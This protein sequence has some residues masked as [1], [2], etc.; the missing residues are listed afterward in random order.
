MNFSIRTRLTFWYTSLLFVSL[1]AFG[2]AFSYSLLKIFIYRTDNQVSSVANMM[3]HTI[4]KPSGEL[5]LPR[6]FDI[7]LERFFGIRTAGNYIQVLDPHGQVVAKS[8]NLVFRMPIPKA[9]YHAALGGATTFEVVKNVG[10]YPVRVVTKP[11]FVNE[12]LV[13]IVQVGSSLEDMDEVFNSLAY[14]F[15]FGML[16][17]VVVAGGVGWFLAK[18]ALKPVSVITEAARR[19]EA[20]NLNER[21]EIKVPQDE[22]GRLASTMNEMIGRLEKSFRQ[23]R[24]FT[25]DASH[26]LKTPL[27]IMK[28]EIEIALRSKGD[29]EYLREVLASNLEAIDRMSYIV[30]NLLDLAKMDVE[31]GTTA[32]DVVDLGKV[33]SDRCEQF[34]RLALDSGVRL[35][36]LENKELLVRGD[37]V[38]ISQLVFNLIDNAIKYTPAGG[39]VEALL[40][41]EGG[42][43]VFKVR[44]TGIGISAEDLSYIFDRFYRVDKAR[45][46]VGGAGLG[47]SI[48]KEIAEAHGGTITVESVIGSGSVFTVSLPIAAAEEATAEPV[49]V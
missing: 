32:H 10:R 6:D 41:K 20:E 25:G 15:I 48:C 17:S 4:V 44:D 21:I 34:K 40:K 29:A 43:A 37:H 36:M 7:F 13:A 49:P 11:I 5:F 33:V 23:I 28:G 35:D 38:R 19:I 9:T 30:M 2:A 18:K 1:I 14:I 22:I 45:K 24:Q 8:S 3:V 42:W 16:A 12:K 39:S 26:E 31:K 47:L 27:T 46:N